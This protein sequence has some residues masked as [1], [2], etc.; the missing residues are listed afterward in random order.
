MVGVDVFVPASEGVEV[1]VVISPALPV[2]VAGVVA[3]VVVVMV[4]V[5]VGTLVG[6]VDSSTVCSLSLSLS[7][8]PP[9]PLLLLPPVVLASVAV[10][11]VV[12]GVVV[13]VVGMVVAAV[14]S[15][16][17][18]VAGVTY[19]RKYASRTIPLHAAQ[20]TSRLFLGS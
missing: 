17:H 7:E 5:A 3:V 6:V 4:V 8:L 18:P 15:P 19:P 12:G 11:G 10:V 2:A 9:L 16:T 14:S 13:G 20:I 1:V